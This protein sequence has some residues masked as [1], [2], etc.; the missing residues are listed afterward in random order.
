VLCTVEKPFI[1][2]GRLTFAKRGNKKYF[3]KMSKLNKNKRFI[4]RE[5]RKG[6]LC[7]PTECKSD[8]VVVKGYKT[9]FGPSF[10]S[11]AVCY[12]KE[13]KENL[14]KGL[15]RITGA[16]K[17]ETKGL[18]EALRENQIVNLEV[19]QGSL[20]SDKLFRYLTWLRELIML[21]LLQLTSDYFNVIMEGAFK[22]HPKMALRIRSWFKMVE[23]GKTLTL[24]YMTDITGKLK[25]PEW[26]RWM[27]FPRIIADYTC[28]GSLIGGEVVAIAKHCMENWYS[29][30]T[31]RMRFVF[32][33]VKTIV[34]HMFLAVCDT[35][36]FTFVYH[37]DDGIAGIPCTDGHL[38][39]NLDISSCDTSNGVT[40]FNMLLWLFS[41]SYWSKLIEVCV[42]QCCKRLK[43]CN[44]NAPKEKVY[45][46]SKDP[47][48]YSGTVLTTMLNNL[49]MSCIGLSI[50][51]H[52]HGKNLT[53]AQTL[54]VIGKAAAKV[55]YIVT[56]EVA[57]RL[58]DLQ[59]LKMTPYTCDSGEIRVFTNLGVILRPI[60][61]C[62]GDLPGIGCLRRR[63]EHWNA[64]LVES[65][66]HAG[67]SSVIRALRKRF[68]STKIVSE[69]AEETTKRLHNG[70]AI[71]SLVDDDEYEVPDS[72]LCARYNITQ[73]ELTYLN[74]CIENAELFSVLTNSVLQKIFAKDYGL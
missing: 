65:F 16:R 6:L 26:A 53:K 62:N 8:S 55:G 24:D 30:G 19:C 36:Y 9:V 57:E 7:F 74:E 73:A 42:Q 47:I 72:A 48:E 51:F 3:V 67:N 60:G 12:A 29:E 5:F 68:P 17:P 32:R 52:T 45:F 38:M 64:Q 10:Y 11:G 27:K 56:I 2:N 50:H 4:E 18:C 25:V 20:W 28:P 44:P 15:T 35:R 41:L 66:K 70:Y 49:A 34:A 23:Q 14:E 13:Y 63:A 71:E 43:I 61:S 59:F 58:E 33:P 31:L 39:V 69:W 37:S 40:I 22:K 54:D 21:A 46:E 1:P